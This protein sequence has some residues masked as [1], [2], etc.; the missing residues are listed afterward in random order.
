VAARLYVQG[1]QLSY[2]MVR[3]K[4]TDIS[5]SEPDAMPIELAREIARQGDIRLSAL[6]AL[7]TAADLRATNGEES[8]RLLA[9]HRICLIFAAAPRLRR[10]RRAGRLTS[11]APTYSGYVR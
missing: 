7:A 11:P 5:N 9:R 1:R 3:G 2:F 8:N 10:D 6:M 4:M